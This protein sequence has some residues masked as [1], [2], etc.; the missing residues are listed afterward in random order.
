MVLFLETKDRCL[1]LVDEPEAEVSNLESSSTWDV[2][3]VQRLKKLASSFEVCRV[4]AEASSCIRL[5]L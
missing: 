1:V 2:P 4:S 3:W 5:A